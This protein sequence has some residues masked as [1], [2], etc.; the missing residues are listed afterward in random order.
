MAV[1]SLA[2]LNPFGPSD[3][4]SIDGIASEDGSDAFVVDPYL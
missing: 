1:R 4:I 2:A 3:G